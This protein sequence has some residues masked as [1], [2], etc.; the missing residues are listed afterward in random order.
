LLLQTVALARRPAAPRF[1]AHLADQLVSG[2]QRV[3]MYFAATPD[4]PTWIKGVPLFGRRLAAAWDRIVEV[5]GNLRAL[6]EP[7]TANLEQL[8]PA[9]DF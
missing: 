9:A 5:R 1:R 2:A 7:Y 3:Q 8:R 6:L 4:Q